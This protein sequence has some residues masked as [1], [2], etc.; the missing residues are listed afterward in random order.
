MKKMFCEMCD[1]TEFVKEDGLFVCQEC[2]CKY[3]PEE[4]R[5]LMKEVGE[6]APAQEEPKAEACE[7]PEEEEESIPLHTPDSPNK[8]SV[9]VLKVGHET[10]TT[11]SVTSLSVLLGGEPAPVFV[12][13]PDQVGHIGAQISLRHITGKPIKYATVYL[14]PYNAVGDTVCCTVQEHSVFGIEITGPIVAGD[15]WE[16]YSDGMWYNNSIVGAKIDRV[17][18]IYM[19][20]TEELYEGKE[21]YSTAGSGEEADANGLCK[22]TVVRNEMQTSIIPQKLTCVLDSDESFGLDYG[23]AVTLHVSRGTHKITFEFAGKA[24]VPAKC[25]STPEFTVDGDVTIELKRDL[26]WGGFKTNILK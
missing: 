21:F 12:D 23:E 6:E 19:D 20:G 10:Y 18:C 15:K 1:S 4:A 7:E 24:L 11:A 25:K 22:L 17:H 8:I 16:G 5:K 14:A 3:P 9:R 13:G 2:G 26:V